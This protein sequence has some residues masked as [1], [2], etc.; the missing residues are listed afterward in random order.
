MARL[1]YTGSWTWQTETRRG[2]AYCIHL[3]NAKPRLRTVRRIPAPFEPIL[4]P[5]HAHSLNRGSNDARTRTAI[6]DHGNP[7]G[8]VLATAEVLDGPLGVLD[9]HEFIFGR[10]MGLA[11]VLDVRITPKLDSLFSGEKEENQ[12][13]SGKAETKTE[14]SEVPLPPP[15]SKT[16]P[17]SK[18]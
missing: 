17:C 9:S 12:I 2:R 16:M 5:I 13:L 7:G 3:L 4:V 1:H 15:G 11:G 10:L 6:V 14:S 8:L 18:P